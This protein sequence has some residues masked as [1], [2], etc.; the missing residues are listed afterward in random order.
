MRIAVIIPAAG[1]GKRFQEGASGTSKVEH[2]LAGKPV[3]LRS[4]ELFLGRGDVAGVILAVP[5]DGVDDFRFRW[6]DKLE[7]H[8]VRI[9][10]GGTKERWET[11]L[12]AL[13]AVP[14]D[15]THV[16]V[17]DAARPLASEKLIG[18]VFEAAA[19]HAAVVPGLA[20]A[21]TLKRV[22]EDAGVAGGDP[23]DAI[24]GGAGR[25]DVK[26]VV[27]TV[28]RRDLVEVQTPQVF[29]LG[30][31]RRAYEQLAAG[32]VDSARITDDASLVEALGD[33]ANPVVVVEGEPT[34]FKITRAADAE[35]ATALIHHR[36]QVEAKQTAVKRLF[37]ED[38]D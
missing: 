11:V 17:H 14:A 25:P 3:F 6:G 9:V 10:P 20:V 15:A 7:F 37:G 24:L 12:R 1:A 18:R 23:L 5:P 33:P 36:T 38:D 26:T 31:L 29:E 4:V 34:N 32:S 13:D 16:A 22:R 19:K 27:E 28:D 2:D 35:L 21:N 30:L 8:G